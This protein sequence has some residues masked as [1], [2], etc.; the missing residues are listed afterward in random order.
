MQK[1]SKEA[2][3]STALA[4]WLLGKCSHF[5]ARGEN[6][7]FTADLIRDPSVFLAK[8]KPEIT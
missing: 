2:R 7:N 5:A 4:R 6:R 8:P 3:Y 1:L